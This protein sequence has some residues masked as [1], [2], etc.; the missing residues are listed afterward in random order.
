LDA[1]LGQPHPLGAIEFTMGDGDG[2]RGTRIPM[3]ATSVV[4]GDES[5]H[6]EFE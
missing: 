1:A 2:R 6:S 5:G 4:R 3:I